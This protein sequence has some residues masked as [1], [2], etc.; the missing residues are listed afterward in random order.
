MWFVE[1]ASDLSPLHGAAL[2]VVSAD[3]HVIVAYPLAQQE[4][5]RFLTVRGKEIGGL[6]REDGRDVH[7]RCPRFEREDGAV[8]PSGVQ[9]LIEWVLAEDEPRIK[10]VWGG[11]VSV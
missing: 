6:Q 5:K 1:E 3:K 10:V 7:V 8:T 4:P 2:Q 11:A 9:A